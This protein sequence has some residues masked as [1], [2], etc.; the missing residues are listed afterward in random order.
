MTVAS[1]QRPEPSPSV[2]PEL[3]SKTGQVLVTVRKH[4][5]LVKRSGS[6][7][8]L[9]TGKKPWSAGT[10]YLLLH[11]DAAQAALSVTKAVAGSDDRRGLDRID[12]WI[13]AAASCGSTLLFA[14]TSPFSGSLIL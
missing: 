5:S 11:T 7:A 2:R 13:G 10:A 9:L 6:F 14:L 3:L 8:K 12:K 1:K 4:A